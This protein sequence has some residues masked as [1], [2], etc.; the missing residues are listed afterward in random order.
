[1]R[2]FIAVFVAYAALVSVGHAQ[3]VLDDERA[4]AHYLAGESH[5][6]A[7]RWPDA[8]REFQSAYELSHRQEMLINLSRAHERGGELSAAIADLESLLETFPDTNYRVEAEQ[9][10]EVMRAKLHPAPALPA[11]EAPAPAKQPVKAWPP[12]W[13]T[14]AFGSVAIAAGVASLGTGLRAHALHGDLEDQCPADRCDPG[15]ESARD[16]GR[17]LSR[18]S[19]GLMFSSIA[20]AGVTATLWVVDYRRDKRMQ[21]GINGS[22]AQLRMQF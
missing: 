20:L 18:V 7:E 8:A 21:L 12:R 15:F 16:K 22:S 13:Y 14:L 4:R 11:V 9:R 17:T 2:L 1:M 5:F 6:A 3:E 19:T 10:L